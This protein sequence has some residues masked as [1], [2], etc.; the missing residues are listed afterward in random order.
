[1]GCAPI[2]RGLRDHPVDSWGGVVTDNPP[3]QPD[4]T[5]PRDLIGRNDTELLK[6]SEVAAIFNVTAR[7]VNGWLDAGHMRYIA[8]PGRHR[9]IP[10]AEARRYLT[11][12]RGPQ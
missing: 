10:V 5:M 1:M 11:L 4:A 12:R 9:R 2:P 7:C 6:P 8:L 3:E